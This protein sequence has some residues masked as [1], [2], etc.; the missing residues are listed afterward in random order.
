MLA[1]IENYYERL[2][3]DYIQERLEDTE[4]GRDAGLVE[5]LVCLALNTLP[6]R[7]VRHAVDLVSHLGYE[8]R[9]IMHREVAEAVETALATMRRRRVTRDPS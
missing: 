5:D 8:D 7:Y 2:V 3:L 9:E 4:E 1:N 6:P